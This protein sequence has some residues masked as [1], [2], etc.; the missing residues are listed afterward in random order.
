LMS[1]ETNSN[2]V[3]KAAGVRAGISAAACRVSNAAGPMAHKAMAQVGKHKT[4]IAMAG[5]AIGGMGALA[6][7]AVV[8]P[9]PVKDRA[10][11]AAASAGDTVAGATA[12][13]RQAAG[14]AATTARDA[15]ASAGGKIAGAAA[16]ARQAAGDVAA[17]VK[18]V[19][20]AATDAY[21]GA[22][23]RAG[24]AVGERVAPVASKALGVSNNPLAGWAARTGK[25]MFISR[26]PALMPVAFAA[27]MATTLTRAGSGA[28]ATRRAR[29][30]RTELAGTVVREKR[31]LLFFKG[32]E[33]VAMWRSSMTD[34]LNRADLMGSHR[35]KGTGVH[36]SDGVMFETKGARTWH[37][38][39]SVVSTSRGRRTV[40]HLQSLT[41]PGEHHYFDRRISD[42]QAVGIATGRLEAPKV[43]GYVSSISPQESL[44]PM[45][46]ASKRAAINS[47]LYWGDRA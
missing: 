45:W 5:L 22:L 21:A 28:A 18:G 47:V 27:G 39:T 1:C 46:A 37:R 6:A 10:R 25:K 33:A 44:V 26:N 17:S 19:A 34:R 43:P 36:A 9:A 41:L 30:S 23:D 11:T 20:G 38:G 16:S 13:A 8:A 29:A 42:E 24:D 14:D 35:L 2:K 32:K 15:A 31:Q 7:G 3:G 12:S 40:T 4:P